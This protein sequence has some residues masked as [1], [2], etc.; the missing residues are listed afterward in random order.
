LVQHDFVKKTQHVS[1]FRQ[2]ESGGERREY[3]DGRPFVVHFRQRRH[4][5]PP[6]Q[7]DQRNG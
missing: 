6:N 1:M 7:S 2:A 3:H 4:V 5:G